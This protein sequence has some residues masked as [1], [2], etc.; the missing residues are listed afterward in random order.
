M[1]SSRLDESDLEGH[2]WPCVHA[3][4]GI[5]DTTD[6]PADLLVGEGEGELRKQ[7]HEHDLYTRHERGQQSEVYRIVAA[8]THSSRAAKT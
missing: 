8:C 1:F 7:H 3:Y 4:G 5:Q 6:V 2:C